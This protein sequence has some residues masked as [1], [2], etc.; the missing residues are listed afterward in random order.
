MA[1]ARPYRPQSEFTHDDRLV[2]DRFRPTTPDAQIRRIR[3]NLVRDDPQL[4]TLCSATTIA[5]TVTISP[6]SDNWRR[7]TNTAS[8]TPFIL[9]PQ[10]MRDEARAK[11]IERPLLVHL[12]VEPG[13]PSAAWL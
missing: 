9:V 3:R 13:R 1:T 11:G 12:P 5:V 8:Y 7:F 10:G 4:H 6:W 2:E